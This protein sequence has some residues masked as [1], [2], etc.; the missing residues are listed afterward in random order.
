M[1]LSLLELLLGLVV[2][3]F[4]LTAT[5]PVLSGWI[6]D[7][8]IRSSASSLLAALHTARNEAITRNQTV[9]LTLVDSGGRPGWTMGCVMVSATCP[10]VLRQQSVSSTEPVRWAAGV[11]SAT[12]GFAN[13]MAPGEGLPVSVS[14]SALGAAPRVAANL[15]AARI[16]ISHRESGQGHWL[17]VLISSR[18]QVRLCDPQRAITHPLSCA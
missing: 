3:S 5:V 4:L 6:R 8:E 17:A 7:I 11:A 1:A 9:R 15:D 13:P 14:F 12:L 2:S 18:G 16:D 10:Q